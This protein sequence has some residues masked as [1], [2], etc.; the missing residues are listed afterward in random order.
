MNILKLGYLPKTGG[1]DQGLP[2]PIFQE[3]VKLL[4][5]LSAAFVK[6]KSFLLV[7]N[8]FLIKVNP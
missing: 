6:L 8:G 1:I 7:T 3:G 4:V 2:E 5:N